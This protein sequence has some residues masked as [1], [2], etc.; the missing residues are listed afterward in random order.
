MAILVDDDCASAQLDGMDAKRPQRFSVQIDEAHLDRA[1]NLRR[2]GRR[3]VPL[4]AVLRAALVLG[5][6]A[7]AIDAALDAPGAKMTGGRS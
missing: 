1:T 6:D 7:P 5:L 2:R 4:A 3:I